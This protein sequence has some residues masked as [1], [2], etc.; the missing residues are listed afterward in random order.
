MVKLQKHKAYTY[1]TESGEAIDHFKYVINVPEG[2]L[3]KLGWNDGQELSLTI[4]DNSLTLK[5]NNNGSSSAKKKKH[6]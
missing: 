6:K 1:R 4:S 2:A 5:P 3:N